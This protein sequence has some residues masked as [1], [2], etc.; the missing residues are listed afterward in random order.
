MRV[1]TTNGAASRL[2]YTETF[3]TKQCDLT[4]D[5]CSKLYRSSPSLTEARHSSSE[6]FTAKYGERSDFPLIK[7]HKLHQFNHFMN[8]L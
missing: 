1:A 7:G 2:R 3:H 4:N 5:I 6:Q 8:L